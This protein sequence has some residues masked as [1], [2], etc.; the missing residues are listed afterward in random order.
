MTQLTRF[1]KH[2][3]E[4]PEVLSGISVPT[5]V[6]TWV[7]VNYRAPLTE[8]FVLSEKNQHGGRK[9]QSFSMHFKILQPF[10]LIS[11]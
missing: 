4:R 8:L 6:K 3:K 2:V 7:I 10:N 11:R 1:Y 5:N 9:E